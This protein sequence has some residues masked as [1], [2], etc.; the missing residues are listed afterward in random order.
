MPEAT[1]REFLTGGE[2]RDLRHAD[3][4]GGRLMVCSELGAGVVCWTGVDAGGDALG[5][6]VVF[7]R[8]RQ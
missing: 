2:C 4:P 7:G 5:D 8:H 3:A 1:R 6:P